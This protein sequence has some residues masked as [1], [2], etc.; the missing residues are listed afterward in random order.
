M[1]PNKVPKRSRDVSG[2]MAQP[3]PHSI[4]KAT[5]RDAI[6]A[7]AAGYDALS[8]PVERRVTLYLR[9]DHLYAV[10]GSDYVS[11]GYGQRCLSSVVCYD[12]AT[13]V[14]LPVAPMTTARAYHGVA[15]L[16]GMLYAVGG[17]DGTHPLTSV[18]RYDPAINVW[19]VVAP[20]TT[21][22]DSHGV[23]VLGG[24]L[25]AVGGR[26]G[27]RPLSSVERFDPATNV[28]SPVAP[29]TTARADLKC[30]DSIHML[31]SL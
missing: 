2:P 11:D 12:P 26:D 16:E 17:H 31:E 14:W 30:A 15:V 25:Y 27:R 7:F 1:P 20:M 3:T 9:K 18:E 22:R 4:A 19:S 23:A 5:V 8:I 28:W 24:L 13:N 21:A 29:M 6:V 10:G